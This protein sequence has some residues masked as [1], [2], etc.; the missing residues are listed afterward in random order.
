MASHMEPTY[1]REVFPCFDEPRF[2]STFELYLL[3]HKNFSALSNMPVKKTEKIDQNYLQTSFQKSPPMP[4][5]TFAIVLH[6]F[7]SFTIG[8]RNLTVYANPN[9][10]ND[11]RPKFAN[12]DK[13]LEAL[14]K[15]FGINYVLPKM[16]HVFVPGWDA[17]GFLRAMEN[18]G[19]TIFM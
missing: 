12:A 9:Y 18:W 13:I 17:Q 15:Y 16:D 6:E 3:H 7:P 4:T 11:V 19:L 8:N 10:I 14:E 1:A 2:K 5:Y